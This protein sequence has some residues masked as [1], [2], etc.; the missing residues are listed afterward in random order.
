[1]ALQQVAALNDDTAAFKD[2]VDYF[3]LNLDESN[4]MS[5]EGKVKILGNVDKRKHEK[6][7]S[8]SQESITTVKIGSAAGTEGPRIYLGTGKKVRNTSMKLNSF[9]INYK[10]PPESH[11]VMTPSAYMADDAW[12]GM[13]I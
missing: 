1:M 8:D 3:T 10:S 5:C 12:K 7:N 4:F 6:N 11:L 2:I 13:T 9:S